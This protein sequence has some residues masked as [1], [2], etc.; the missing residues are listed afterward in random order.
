MNSQKTDCISLKLYSY[1]FSKSCTCCICMNLPISPA[2]GFFV[3]YS[4]P[5]LV[6]VTFKTLLAFKTLEKE[7][8]WALA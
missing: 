4:R 3:L 7:I 5:V 2:V 6:S 1:N 8:E